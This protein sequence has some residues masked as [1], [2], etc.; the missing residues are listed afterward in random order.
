MCFTFKATCFC[1]ANNIKPGDGFLVEPLLA[2]SE[3]TLVDTCN[4]CDQVGVLIETIRALVHQ[5]PVDSNPSDLNTKA[6]C[7]KYFEKSLVARLQDYVGHV[8]RKKHE[9]GVMRQL[10]DKMPVDTCLIIFD[11]K[12]KILPTIYRESMV[13]FFSF[14]YLVLCY[15]VIVV[16][17]VKTMIL[18]LLRHG[19][20]DNNSSSTSTTTAMDESTGNNTSID[21]TTTGHSS[22]EDDDDGGISGELDQSS[23]DGNDNGSS[24][25]E[26]DE[27]EDDDDNN[28][29]NDH[30]APAT[31]SP[32][33]PPS[34][35]ARASNKPKRFTSDLVTE[36]YDNLVVADKETGFVS[37]SV[38]E[39]VLKVIKTSYPHLRRVNLMTDGAAVFKGNVLFSGLANMGA[40][41]PFCL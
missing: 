24:D 10:L 33:T 39:G 41:S 15:Y 25:D 18:Q 19:S 8:V 35:A 38:I 16:H 36:F 34:L 6:V 4:S 12:M 21:D 30:A 20:S 27:R 22:S 3:A 2:E 26:D 29:E 37:L 13:A 32:S 40:G 17:L 28:Q 11:Y 9:A 31:T 7:I 5:L 23:E 14:L 1:Q